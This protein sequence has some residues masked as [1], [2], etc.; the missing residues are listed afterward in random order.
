MLIPVIFTV[1]SD[2]SGEVQA[3]TPLFQG[4]FCRLH[5][6]VYL[7]PTQAFGFEVHQ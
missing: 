3:S 7:L 4:V 2:V 6:Y 1:I 5:T